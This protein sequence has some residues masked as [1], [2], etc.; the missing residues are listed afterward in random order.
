MKTCAAKKR[1]AVQGTG[2]LALQSDRF[3]RFKITSELQEEITDNVGEGDDSTIFIGFWFGFGLLERT[4]ILSPGQV[5]K[6]FR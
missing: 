1:L 3:Y 4:D 6:V 2:P 5:G